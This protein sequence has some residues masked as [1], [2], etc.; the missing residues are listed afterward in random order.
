MGVA[1]SIEQ[2]KESVCKEGLVGKPALFLPQLLIEST[3][4]ILA[5]RVKIDHQS[6]WHSFKQ[7]VE[8]KGERV[9]LTNQLL[10]ANGAKARLLQIRYKG[11]TA[12]DVEVAKRQA[13]TFPAG[14]GY[15]VGDERHLYFAGRFPFQDKNDW[16][17]IIGRT[18]GQNYIDSEWMAQQ[19]F[20]DVKDIP[21]KNKGINLR[22]VG[23]IGD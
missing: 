9:A 18:L 3:P 8:M 21:L 1:N 10:L 5:V 22:I 6:L 20:S 11:L 16:L 17:R 7:P 13:V 23:V 12:A 14:H 15:F 19:A 2:Q 4:E